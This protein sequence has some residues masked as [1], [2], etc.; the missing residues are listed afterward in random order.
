[1]IQLWIQ[2]RRDLETEK[3][4]WDLHIKNCKNEKQ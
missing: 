4:R 1:M 2:K 3:S